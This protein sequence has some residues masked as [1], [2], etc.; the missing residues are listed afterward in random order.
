MLEG[1]TPESEYKEESPKFTPDISIVAVTGNNII[2]SIQSPYDSSYAYVQGG[3]LLGAAELTHEGGTGIAFSHVTF[4][5][6]NPKG[7][8]SLFMHKSDGGE[9]LA[10]VTLN[11]NGSSFDAVPE[12]NMWSPERIV[13]S[14]ALNSITDTKHLSESIQTAQERLNFFAMQTGLNLDSVKSKQL[15]SIEQSRLYE[16]SKF[17]ISPEELHR[18][19]YE[20][21]PQWLPGDNFNR[22]ITQA[23][24]NGGRTSTMGQTEDSLLKQRSA[25]FEEKTSDLH[26]FES[27]MSELLYKA[28]TMLQKIQKGQSEGTLWEEFSS[29]VESANLQGFS[30]IPG[31]VIPTASEIMDEAIKLYFRH[32]DELAEN[33]AA[34]GR[35]DNRENRRMNDPNVGGSGTAEVS[36][37]AA[38]LPAETDYRQARLARVTKAIIVAANDIHVRNL[39]IAQGQTNIQRDRQIASNAMVL[40]AS[41]AV[42]SFEHDGNHAPKENVIASVSGELA[43][44][45][46]IVDLMEAEQDKLEFGEKLERVLQNMDFG[47]FSRNIETS[48]KPTSENTMIIVIYGSGQF[49]GDEE[50]GFDNLSLSLRKDYNEVWSFAS[51]ENRSEGI[52]AVNPNNALDEVQSFISNRHK[53]NP[54]LTYVVLVG[55]SWGGG[56]VHD[57]SQ[58]LINES[59]LELNIASTVY[60]DAVNHKSFTAE[61]R[62][63]PGTNSMLNIFQSNTEVLQDT[64]LRLNG[65]PITTTMKPSLF[66]EIDL[67]D[68]G[69]NVTHSSI[70]EIC[71][72]YIVEF[73]NGIVKSAK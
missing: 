13:Q 73:V 9:L 48:N 18:R 49:P 12:E 22:L 57:V 19:I 59:G 52:I 3:G 72:P 28:V 47:K 10:S 26:K 17:F 55:Y 44:L 14:M 20:L 42:S 15:I 61:N 43:Y 34:Q 32:T 11:W 21:H 63:P 69:N 66:D 70:D 41:S 56:V 53:N 24:E 71:V 1:N 51:G 40:A 27:I 46:D 25:Y 38:S 36:E 65:G 31:L 30:R 37:H 35:I 7:E 23:W 39:L 64:V 67:D 33:M 68:N 54:K 62:L 16:D 60:I 29:S 5:T 8:Y 4:K 6:S 58:W 2:F 45:G 50:S